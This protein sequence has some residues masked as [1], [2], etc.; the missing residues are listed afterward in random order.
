MRIMTAITI[1]MAAVN[2]TASSRE[3]ADF[4]LHVYV[5]FEAPIDVS[6][7]LLAQDRAS[8]LLAPTSVRLIWHNTPFGGSNSANALAMTF[9]VTA[10]ASHRTPKNEHALAAAWP[11]A[12]GRQQILVFN[13]RVASFIAPYGRRS[14][15]VVGHILAHEIGHLLEGIVRHSDSGLM[16]AK[17]TPDDLQTITREG[18]GLAPFDQELIRANLIRREANTVIAKQ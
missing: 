12:S 18:L 5:T 6:L 17:W 3:S 1:L 11:Y 10:P 2:A 16:R 15:L 13:D 7:V 8:K 14:G 9:M 4:T